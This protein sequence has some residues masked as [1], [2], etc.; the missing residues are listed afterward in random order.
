MKN[1]HI[2]KLTVDATEIDFTE[3]V[4]IT[5]MMRLFEITAFNHADVL[6]LDHPN[7]IKQGS[8]FWVTTKIKMQIKNEIT[9]GEVLRVKTWTQTPG[10][11][12]FIRNGEIRSK[13]GIKAKIKSEW[14]CLDYETHKIRKASSI[15]WPEM[16]MVDTREVNLEF[17]TLKTD[18]RAQYV[19]TRTVRATDIDLNFHTNNLKYNFFALDAFSVDELKAMKIKEWEIHFLNESHEGDAIEI[20]KQKIKNCFVVEGRTQ[21][22][23]IFRV[24]I[25]TKK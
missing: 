1:A 11:I 2:N 9:V 25:S 21:E 14:C 16:E 5:E 8:A 10:A 7:M 6:G 17:S 3:R 4:P 13:S 12:R 23:P 15:N 20:Y 18:E 19:Y 24:I 22:K